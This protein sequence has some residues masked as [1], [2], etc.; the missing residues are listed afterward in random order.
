MF[1]WVTRMKRV[2]PMSRSAEDEQSAKGE[3]RARTLER[4]ALSSAP[5]DPPPLHD[6]GLIGDMQTAALVSRFGSI[7]WACFPRFASP[8]VFGRI[9]DGGR[10]GHCTIAPSEPFEAVQRYLPSTAILETTFHLPGVR[11]LRLLDFMPLPSAAGTE[12][13]PMIV[14]LVEALSG[15]VEVRAVVDPRF[16][17]GRWPARW[18]QVGSRWIGRSRRDSLSYQPGWTVEPE[19]PGLVGSFVLDA[20]DRAAFEL[21]WGT[22]RPVA[23]PAV[24]LLA[25]TERFWKSWVHVPDSPIHHLAG[26]WHPWVERS[27][28][29]LKLLSRSDTGAFVAAPTTSLP[30]WPGGARN[31]DYRYVWVRDAAFAA[32]SLLLMGHVAEARSFLHWLLGLVSAAPTAR[33]LRVVYGAHGQTNLTERELPWLSG[34]RDARPVRVGNGAAVQFQLDIYGELLDAVL[35]LSEIEE[36]A[37]EGW[38]PALAQL[39][40]SVVRQWRAPDRG[41]WEIRAPPAHYVHSKVMAWVAL[42]RAIAL[43]HEFGPGE[44]V[45]RWEAE[46]DRIRAVV[47]ARGYDRRRDSFIQAF[48]RRFD[49][50]ANLRIPLVGFLSPDDPRVAGTVLRVERELTAGPFVYRYRAADGIEGP[51]GAFLA[52]SFWLV[53]CIA[54]A[55]QRRRA[56]Q[57]FESLLR[58]GSPLGLLSEQYDPIGGVALGNY[59]QAFSHIALLRAA[60]SLGLATAPAEVFD[61]YPWLAHATTR[62]P[63]APQAPIAIPARRRS[64]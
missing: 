25:R 56:R 23:P 52:S 49:D 1:F 12:G 53:D 32:Q 62:R 44:T 33:R 5:Y 21:Y 54:R 61:Q 45:A 37:V 16:D 8:S 24:D 64:A 22:E 30:E 35:L 13:A 3:A 46:R 6:Y 31:W 17:Y 10:G 27:E 28:L 20:G 51:E 36:G 50:A 19:G 39:A 40:D 34:Y 42:D 58:S 60:L 9:L 29:T 14:R 7:D 57:R 59:P 4:Q 48:D 26:K 11:T 47:L 38:W 15:S 55:G 2:H 18:S 43:G 63:S 41:I